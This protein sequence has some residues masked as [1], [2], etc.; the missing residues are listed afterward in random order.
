MRGFD[1]S[2][3]VIGHG[4]CG[5]RGIYEA[6][7][8]KI[9]LRGRG[10]GHIESHTGREAPAHLMLSVTVDNGQAESFRAAVRMAADHLAG[11]QDRFHAFC[12]HWRTPVPEHRCFWVG[13]IEAASKECLGAALGGLG[14]VLG[15]KRAKGGKEGW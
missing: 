3:K 13:E 11:I 8:A 12:R 5:T 15:A 2:K 9:R 7:G 10:S 4:G 1:L 6:T 14:I